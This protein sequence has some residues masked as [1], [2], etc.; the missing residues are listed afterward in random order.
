MQ[1]FAKACT[2]TWHV[3][4]QQQHHQRSRPCSEM[5]S[6]SPYSRDFVISVESH[7]AEVVHDFPWR[8]NCMLTAT[9]CP[10]AWHTPPWKQSVIIIVFFQL[11]L[12]SCLWCWYTSCLSHG[13]CFAAYV[14]WFQHVLQ[15]HLVR[16]IFGWLMLHISGPW[17]QPLCG[18]YFNTS[19]GISFALQVL[20]LPPIWEWR[21]RVLTLPS[22]WAATHSHQAWS[23]TIWCVRMLKSTQ[24]TPRP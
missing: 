4:F 23:A 1:V 18:I 7:S 21:V 11:H 6:K 19:V 17:P 14:Q 3:A 20:L 16:C 5:D 22:W 9:T 12:L 10:H 24:H 8:M 13:T 15:R 2:W